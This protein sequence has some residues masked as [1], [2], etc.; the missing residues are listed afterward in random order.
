MELFLFLKFIQ[1]VTILQTVSNQEV[2]L[3]KLISML[4]I[5]QKLYAGRKVIYV[6]RIYCAYND[7]T[8]GIRLFDKKQQHFL[9]IQDFFVYTGKKSCKLE[10]L[11]DISP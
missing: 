10:L 6:R 9:F 1:C 5:A 8:K 4:R 2:T 11:K 7:V 3:K